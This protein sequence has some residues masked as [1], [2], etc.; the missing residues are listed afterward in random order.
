MK[1]FITHLQTHSFINRGVLIA[2]KINKTL[3]AEHNKILLAMT[4]YLSYGFVIDQ[5]LIFKCTLNS[6]DLLP[7]NVDLFSI[8]SKNL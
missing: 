5:P 4:S 3:N 1:D 8:T 7:C 6:V 2:I